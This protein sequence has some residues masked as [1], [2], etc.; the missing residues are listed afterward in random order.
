MD[1]RLDGLRIYGQTDTGKTIQVFRQN[2][3]SSAFSARISFISP[4]FENLRSATQRIYQISQIPRKTTGNVSNLP[5]G[6][7][8]KPTSQTSMPR[9]QKT[10]FAGLKCK[11]TCCVRD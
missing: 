2:E 3:R 8:D 5:F 11:L 9:K 6:R 10:L 4:L 1:G 7:M